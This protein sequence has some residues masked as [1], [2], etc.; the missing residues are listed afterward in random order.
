MLSRSRI[1]VPH[2]GHADRGDMIDWC[3][4]TR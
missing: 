1:G 3:R 4:G 2:T